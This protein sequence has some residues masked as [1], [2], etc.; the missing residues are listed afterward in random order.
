MFQVYAVF[1]KKAKVFASPYIAKHQAEAVRNIARVANDENSSLNKYAEDFALYLVCQ[2]SE[3]S[4]I[5]KECVPEMVTE[6][7]VLIDR[8]GV[9]NG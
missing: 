6:I 2:F 3:E 1:D 8:K 4:A 7:A 5:V 9:N